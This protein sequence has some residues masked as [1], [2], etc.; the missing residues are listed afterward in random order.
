MSELG[1]GDIAIIKPH[2]NPRLRLDKDRPSIETRVHAEVLQTMAMNEVLSF[3]N[4]AG[5]QIRTYT[6][7]LVDTPLYSK[8][9][10]PDKLMLEKL[11]DELEK[12]VVR[13]K[14]LK[15]E[16]ETSPEKMFKKIT[17][18]EPKEKP[19]I[20][21]SPIDIHVT[22]SGADFDLLYRKLLKRSSRAGIGGFHLHHSLTSPEFNQILLVQNLQENDD[23]FNH[24]LF[25]AHE[26]RHMTNALVQDFFAYTE[27]NE[28]DPWVILKIK[29]QKLRTNFLDTYLRHCRI[30]F[31]QDVA[32]EMLAMMSEPEPRYNEYFF[33]RGS[34][35]P[36]NYDYIKQ[37]DK[38]LAE[39][40]KKWAP[41][42]IYGEIDQAVAQVF[43]TE[44]NALIRE[45]ITALKRL[46]TQ[47]SIDEREAADFL[48]RHPFPT[49]QAVVTER[50]S[51]NDY[52]KTAISKTP[53]V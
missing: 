22:T 24:K 26:R 8:L 14:D 16:Y 40:L 23:G 35:T 9:T 47:T 32:D 27:K 52:I 39:D 49:W 2:A 15:E 48:A 34:K 42:E 1:G 7:L 19:T 37:W 18:Q 33:V 29:D 17:G 43:T 50:I 44:Y 41:I 30:S 12:R 51:V 53:Q 6:E 28:P 31:D 38:E 3:A 5:G 45:N 20:S 10:T 36:P 13:I 21:F 11:A 46:I 4:S 25:L